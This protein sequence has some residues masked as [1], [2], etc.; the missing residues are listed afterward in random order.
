MQT[1]RRY[2]ANLFWG[3]LILV[4]IGLFAW[5]AYLRLVR[6]YS[7]ADWTGIGSFTAP[8]GTFIRAKTLWD[9]VDLLLT[10]LVI[11][12]SAWLLFR[13]VRWL[14]M[15]IGARQSAVAQELARRER[16]KDR[17]IAAESR[18]LK[19]ETAEAQRLD[20]LLRE[21]IEKIED[22]L[23]HEGLREA[24]EDPEAHVRAIAQART[25]ATL[26]LLDAGHRSV[27]LH[28]LRSSDL[29]DS[30][31]VGAAMQDINL[32]GSDL[33]QLNLTRCDLS[34]CDLSEASLNEVKLSEARL[35][36]ANL[37][38]ARLTLVN[39]KGADLKH[40]DLGKVR[41]SQVNLTGANLT[42]ADLSQ[43]YLRGE[44]LSEARLSKANLRQAVLSEARL[45][46]A[47]LREADLSG[48]E[49]VQA[50]LSAANLSAA[51][52][53]EARLDQA[54]L[55]LVNLSQAVL[56]QAVLNDACLSQADLT[57]AYLD[58]ASLFGADFSGAMLTE[59]DISGVDLSGTNFSADQM[60]D[61]K[62]EVQEEVKVGDVDE[63]DRV[64]I[65]ENKD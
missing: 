11:I 39:L 40:A 45:T 8:D 46:A 30:L 65:G 29:S 24:K 55:S 3:L 28:F 62:V 53:R 42:G 47:D 60:R 32:A 36:D 10:P 57:G 14:L 22:L 6:Q 49:L 7:W 12:L 63:V 41:M 61:V 31:L 27:L 44:N 48:A 38:R 59:A 58:N 25:V 54:D 26:R 4:V 51:V 9:W 21:Y 50:Q 19:Q 43:A 2:L 13:A 23:M 34:R 56:S 33:A 64:D 35:Q 20:L 17:E 5:G 37:N 18:R 52:L 15:D 16:H 1:R